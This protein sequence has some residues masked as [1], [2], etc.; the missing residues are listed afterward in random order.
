MSKNQN[1]NKLLKSISFNVTSLESVNDLL[2]NKSKDIL[3]LLS[4]FKNNTYTT[5]HHFATT[6]LVDLNELDECLFKQNL[7]KTKQ[8][9][10]KI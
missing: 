3:S 1:Y 8:G 5:Q 9:F 2:S 4:A 6:Y 7:I 10:I